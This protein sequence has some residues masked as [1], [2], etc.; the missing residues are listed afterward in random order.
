MP[1]PTL[2]LRAGSDP[3]QHAPAETRLIDDPFEPEA[4]PN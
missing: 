3:C 4:P 2:V 1:P